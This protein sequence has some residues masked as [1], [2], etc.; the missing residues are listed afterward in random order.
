MFDILMGTQ[1][2]GRAEVKKEGL[3]YRFSCTCTPPDNGI[4]RIIVCDGSNTRDIGICR[5]SGTVARVPI[6]YLP[7]DKLTFTLV[8]KDKKE[9]SVPVATGEPFE[10]L[11]QLDNAHLQVSD[12]QPKILID[13][14]PDQQDSDPSQ[15]PP[16]IWEQP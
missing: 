13:P 5:P 6:K 8:P 14:A 10:H 9:I 3:Y 16:H 15:E 2:V 4:Y 7:G 11:D 1:A 12:G